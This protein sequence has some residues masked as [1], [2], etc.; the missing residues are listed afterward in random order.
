MTRRKD[1]IDRSFFDDMLGEV[2][3]ASTPPHNAEVP[4]DQ[5]SPRADQFRRSFDQASIEALAASV[6]EIGLLEP[7]VVRPQGNGFEI[8]AGERRYRALRYLGWERTS[9]RI[10]AF[11]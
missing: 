7:I 3:E 10:V 2:A 9:V 11:G 1:K 4:L 8:V 5:I 6:S